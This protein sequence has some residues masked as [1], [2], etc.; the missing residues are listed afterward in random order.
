MST[1]GSLSKDTIFYYMNNPKCLEDGFSLNRFDL[2]RTHPQIILGTLE[3]NKTQDILTVSG[4]PI[5]TIK[6]SEQK[7][8]PFLLSAKFHSQDGTE[9][10]VV[11]NNVWKNPTTNWDAEMKRREVKIRRKSRDIQLLIEVQPPHTLLVKTLKAYYKGIEISCSN[12]KP[13]S[14]R[15]P[16]GRYVEVTDSQMS[17]CTKALDISH[18]G[19]NLEGC[20]EARFSKLSLSSIRR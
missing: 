20:Q 6:K 18:S 4:E 12:G 3:F 13:F 7:H 19:I 11:E 9:I 8:S 5:L 15:L 16:D 14:V 1:A 10:F 2:G 17:R